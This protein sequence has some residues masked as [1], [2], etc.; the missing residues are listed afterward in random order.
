MKQMVQRCYAAP[1]DAAPEINSSYS[2]DGRGSMRGGEILFSWN[3]D[4]AHTSDW[5][6]VTDSPYDNFRT[7]IPRERRILFLSEPPVIE[8]YQKSYL[9]QFGILVSPSL[10]ST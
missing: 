1:Y 10:L 3:P 6:F 2:E 7:R 8:E 4:D 5:L 9:D